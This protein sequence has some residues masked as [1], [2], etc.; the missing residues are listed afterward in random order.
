MNGGNP[1][2]PSRA[3]RERARA[4][5]ELRGLS[6]NERSHALIKRGL[7]PVQEWAILRFVLETSGSALDHP[8]DPER[9]RGPMERPRE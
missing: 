5:A 2:R 3:Q 8:A 6:P 4:E 1:S 7:R 9:Q